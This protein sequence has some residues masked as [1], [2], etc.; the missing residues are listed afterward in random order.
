MR[1]KALLSDRQW[2]YVLIFYL[3]LELCFYNV[4][5]FFFYLVE[6]SYIHKTFRKLL[7]S[8]RLLKNII[9]VLLFVFLRVVIWYKLDFNTLLLLLPLLWRVHLALYVDQGCWFRLTLF[10]F[11]HCASARLCKTFTRQTFG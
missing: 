5:I 7:L 6:I 4:L 9:I 3:N 2:V 11:T 1:W 10:L 8:P